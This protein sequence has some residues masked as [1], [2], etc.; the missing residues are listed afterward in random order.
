MQNTIKTLG[1]R[2]AIITAASVILS[3]CGGGSGDGDSDSSNDNA[4]PLIIGEPSGGDASLLS[5]E[6]LLRSAVSS[7]SEGLGTNLDSLDRLGND[8]MLAQED[9]DPFGNFIGTPNMAPLENLETSNND[10]LNSSLGID[11]S[12]AT[13]FREG[14]LITINPDD[15]TVC[16]G[17][18]PLNTGINDDMSLCMQLISD[19]TV[20]VNAET[21]QAGLI[22]YLFQSTPFALIGYSPTGVS[23]EVNLGGINNILQRADQLTGSTD[24]EDFF[25]LGAVRLSAVVLNDQIGTEA[26]ELSL[27]VTETIDISDSTQSNRLSLDPSSVFKVTFDEASGDVTT[28]L[29]WGALR[30]LQTASNDSDSMD[31]PLS[32]DNPLSDEGSSQT[33]LNLGGLSAS[34]S[35]NENE[36]ALR[37]TNIGIGNI[38][39]TVTI[40]SIN[41]TLAN[42]GI[43]VDSNSGIVTLDGPLNANFALN[44]LAGILNDQ[45]TDFTAS[46]TLAAPANTSFIPQE[47]GSTQISSGGPLTATLIG[48]DSTQSGQSEVSIDAGECFNNGDDDASGDGVSNLVVEV[49]CD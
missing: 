16:E 39:F 22:T 44:N 4:N 24:A 40:D 9:S 27:D 11:D 17:E 1:L 35:F 32:M 37:V 6:A 8:A 31:D 19:L 36:P 3:A 45:Q 26:G 10:F 42:F 14:N 23:Y 47:N 12:G 13:T 15:Q 25:M 2:F 20:T 49:F 38:P 48:G 28:S 33:E 21:D 34:L 46:A 43:V 18:I 7:V 41:L 29:N 5:D 30:V